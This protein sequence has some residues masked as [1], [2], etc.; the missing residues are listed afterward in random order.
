MAV[1]GRPG[2][3]IVRTCRERLHRGCIREDKVLHEI[4]AISRPDGK[5]QN[6]ACTSRWIRWGWS[7][8]SL[9]FSG[10]CEWRLIDVD[11]WTL[12][13][14][15]DNFYFSISLLNSTSTTL[16]NAFQGIVWSRLPVAMSWAFFVWKNLTPITT[17]FKGSMEMRRVFAF[18]GT[19]SK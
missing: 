5:L 17:A 11:R 15:P 3:H 16:F 13:V 7:A 12:I 14:R 10:V 6:K 19:S 18:T 8:E 2:S 1:A 9:A 4:R